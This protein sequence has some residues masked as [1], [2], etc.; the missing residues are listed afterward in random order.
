MAWRVDVAGRDDVL[1]QNHKMPDAAASKCLTALRAH[2]ATAEYQHRGIG[3]LVERLTAHDDLEL[4]VARLDGGGGCG[5][6]HR[7]PPMGK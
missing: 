4:G 5:F 6:G 3:E 2:A 7:Y 1:I